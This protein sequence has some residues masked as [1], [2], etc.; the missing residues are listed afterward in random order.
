MAPLLNDLVA[1]PASHTSDILGNCHLEKYKPCAVSFAE[2]RADPFWWED[3]SVQV[4]A[5]HPYNFPDHSE[6][7]VQTFKHSLQC[8]GP[9]PPE[10]ATKFTAI[11]ALLGALI[12]AVVSQILARRETLYNMTK[13]CWDICIRTTGNTLTNT[14]YTCLSDCAYR[15]AEASNLV[16]AKFNTALAGYR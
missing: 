15:F 3:C 14:D 9:F 16:G 4:L 5:R 13:L 1:E 10:L 11:C 8:I 12:T 7:S 2:R 6:S